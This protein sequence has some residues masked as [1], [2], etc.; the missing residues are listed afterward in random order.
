MPVLGLF[1]ML[2]CF[3][4]VIMYTYYA[5]SSF[6]ERIQPY[7]WWK[8]YITRIQLTQFAIIGTYGICLQLFHTGYPLL[9]RTLPISQAIIFLYMFGQFYIRSY[10]RNNNNNNRTIKQKS[11]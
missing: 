1:A 4:H 3:C 11:Q 5:L 6:G 7:L 8:H 10:Y 9:Y 2:N